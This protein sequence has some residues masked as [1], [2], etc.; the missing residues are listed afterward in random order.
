MRRLPV[1]QHVIRKCTDGSS[2]TFALGEINL[3]PPALG[4]DGRGHYFYS[5]AGT[6]LFSCDQGPNG[7]VGDTCMRCGGIDYKPWAPYAQVGGSYV[8]I[9]QRSYHEGGVHS[10]MADGSV[11]FIS[12]NIDL[13]LY[14][15]LASK[16]GGEITGSF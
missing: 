13:G 8:R 15:A 16:A 2:N 12:E 3:T 14:Q 6:S 11:R 1:L 5:N 10:G 7:P 9:A 4:W